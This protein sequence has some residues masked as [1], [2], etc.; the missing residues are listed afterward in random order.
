MATKMPPDVILVKF[1]FTNEKRIPRGIPRKE[2]E[3]GGLGLTIKDM[4]RGLRNPGSFEKVRKGRVDTGRSTQIN[5]VSLRSF[6]EEMKR[7]G[8]GITQAHYFEKATKSGEK[9]FVVVLQYCSTE[10]EVAE[11]S[12]EIKD[13]IVLSW[14]FCYLWKNPC[15]NERTTWTVNLMHVITDTNTQANPLSFKKWLDK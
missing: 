10:T 15:E 11:I 13:L 3:E 12:A 14:R 9:K 4:N 1:N 7:F 8:Y 6:V 2:R 5:N